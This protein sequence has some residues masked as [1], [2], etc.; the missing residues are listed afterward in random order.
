M[1]SLVSGLIVPMPTF[2][3]TFMVITGVR[4][5]SVATALVPITRSHWVLLA[6]LVCMYEMA[7]PTVLAKPPN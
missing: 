7:A 5:V 1:C 6:L 3:P 4:Y 2:Q